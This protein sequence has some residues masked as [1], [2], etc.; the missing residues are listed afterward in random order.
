[1]GFDRKPKYTNIA[2]E[3]LVDKGI[4]REE[5][6]DHF[7]TKSTRYIVVN[8]EVRERLQ[9]KLV[10]IVT[11]KTEPDV[12]SFILLDTFREIDLGQCSLDEY[13]KSETMMAKD[14]MLAK[15]LGADNLQLIGPK[16]VHE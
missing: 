2:C 6:D 4:F 16:R 13:E 12:R 1:M 15:A 7:M 10:D 8:T 11:G 5:V 3:M 9:A 14:L